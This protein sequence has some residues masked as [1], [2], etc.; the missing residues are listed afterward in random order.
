LNETERREAQKKDKCRPGWLAGNRLLAA[1]VVTMLL[2]YCYGIVLNHQGYHLPVETKVGGEIALA[3]IE[4]RDGIFPWNMRK[5]ASTTTI[6]LVENTEIP[7]LHNQEE[8][9]TQP[10][11]RGLGGMIQLAGGGLSKMDTVSQESVEPET[12]TELTDVIDF[13]TVTDEYFADAVFIGDSRMVGVY[14]YARI[15]DATFYAKESMTVYGLLESKVVTNDEARTVEEGLSEHRFA[16]VYLMVGINELG[17][18]DTEYFIDA[19]KNVINRIQELQPG[20]IIHIQAIMHV[21]GEKDRNDNIFNN[22]N[23][24]DR[25]EAL[26]A[27]ANGV[28]VF[29]IDV[30]EIYDDVNGNLKEEV[31]ADEIHLLGNCYGPW[32]EFLASHAI[33]WEVSV[34][35]NEIEERTEEE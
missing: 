14:E 10:Y 23:I 27:L 26:M 25:N 15:E 17:T 5:E 21:T 11:F 31:S 9:L 32:H 20:A 6:L 24:N 35:E 34:S 1:I 19:Y 4:I 22:T 3:M 28:D 16:K 30:N 29:Y 33:P 13:T 12:N 2:L 7:F 8:I 18:A